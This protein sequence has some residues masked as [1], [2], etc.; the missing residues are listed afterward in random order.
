[1]LREISRDLPAEPIGRDRIPY[2]VEAQFMPLEGFDKARLSQIAG[3]R[4]GQVGRGPSQATRA[5]GREMCE[6]VEFLSCDALQVSFNFR[7][8]RLFWEICLT[9]ETRELCIVFFGRS[10]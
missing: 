9:S 8:D 2:D 3:R 5:R 1:M 4:G 6:N 10:V 7:D